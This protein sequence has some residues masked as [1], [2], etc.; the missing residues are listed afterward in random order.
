MPGAW[1]QFVGAM[2]NAGP[3]AT[4]LAIAAVPFVAG[5]AAYITK[6]SLQA[7]IDGLDGDARRL[8]DRLADLQSAKDA[9]LERLDEKYKALD[10][11]Y[12][13]MIATRAALQSQ[14]DVIT[15]SVEDMALHLDAKDYSV[16][17]P[18]PTLIPGDRPGELVFLCAS[19]PQGAK[20]RSVRVPVETSMAGQVFLSGTASYSTNGFD[21]P[22]IP[23]FGQQPAT[24]NIGGNNFGSTIILGL[25]IP[26]YDGGVRHALEH[27]ALALM[28]RQ[29]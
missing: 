18:A 16:M 11:R 25:T 17:V 23:G 1:D 4:G 3:L 9:E 6:L 13:A 5:L 2:S 15:A 19:G 21:I 22:T 7:K 24:V 8:K 26:I 10:A 12:R 27:Q 28:D 14:L 20:L 29:V